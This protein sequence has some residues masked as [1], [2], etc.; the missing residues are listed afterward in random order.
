MSKRKYN[1]FFNL[2]IPHRKYDIPNSLLK[3]CEYSSPELSI[4]S[5]ELIDLSSIHHLNAFVDIVT[6]LEYGNIINLCLKSNVFINYILN[7]HKIFNTLYVVKPIQKFIYFMDNNDKTK[8][9]KIDTTSKWFQE[10]INRETTCNKAIKY[11]ICQHCSANQCW[12]SNPRIQMCVFNIETCIE[13]EMCMTIMPSNDE[14]Q[15]LVLQK[16]IVNVHML[17]NNQKKLH[18][19]KCKEFYKKMKYK[20]AKTR[21]ISKFK[22]MPGIESQPFNYENSIENFVLKYEDIHNI[23]FHMF[24]NETVERYKKEKN[25]YDL[26]QYLQKSNGNITL[27][28]IKKMIENGASL[29]YPPVGFI[30]N[31]FSPLIHAMRRYKEYEI[32]YFMINNIDNI[33]SQFNC[34]NKNRM[35]NIISDYFRMINYKI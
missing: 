8:Q 27:F 6:Y 19:F 13:N 30:Y 3:S 16:N 5:I 35:N 4:G 31:G 34:K 32:V 2:C 28:E 17:P 33:E 7:D 18:Y 23:I 12:D 29:E 20:D 21:F 24:D 14:Y 9:W 26:Y 1:Q 10:I 15:Q 11:L 25:T 22:T